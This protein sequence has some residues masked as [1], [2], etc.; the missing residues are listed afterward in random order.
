MQAQQSR[1]GRQPQLDL[2]EARPQRAGT[3]KIEHDVFRLI[4]WLSTSGLVSGAAAPELTL[5]FVSSIVICA[6]AALTNA[7]GVESKHTTCTE[8]LYNL[9]HR[10][11]LG[12]RAQFD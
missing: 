4:C 1:N 3:G 11:E 12:R 10:Q 2:E 5:G 9:S 7:M 8:S 6:A